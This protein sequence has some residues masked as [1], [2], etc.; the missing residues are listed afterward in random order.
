MLGGQ[1]FRL[2]PAGPV[3]AYRTFQATMPKG[4]EFQRPATCEEVECEAWLYGWVTRVQAGTDLEQTI[5]HS[6]RT[7]KR[8]DLVDGWWEFEFAAQTNPCFRASQHR[9]MV[10]PDI[11]QLLVVRGG[12]WRGNPTGERRV[13]QRPEDW[14]EHLHEHTAELAERIEKG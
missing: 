3:Q 5:R 9:T 7:W 4:P 10:R 6:G 14:A 1:P 11:P 2:A 13:H 12:D 8:A